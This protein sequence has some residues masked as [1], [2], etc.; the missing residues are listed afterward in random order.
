MLGF[1]MNCVDA[2]HKK[3]G[4][5]FDQPMP[6]DPLQ[7]LIE[8]AQAVIDISEDL[9]P[10]IK[11]DVRFLRAHL[12]FEEAGEMIKAM[13]EGDEVAALDGASDLQYVLS[14]TCVIFDWPADDAF[15]AVHKS[16]MSKTRKSD[17]PGRVRDKGDTFI[18]PN[19]EKVLEL[20]RMRPSKNRVLKDVEVP[21]LI[22]DQQGA[23]D[24]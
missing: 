9:E 16:N 2:F 24:E 7:E 19:I 21:N 17:D 15:A 11:E 14:G 18:P 20:H 8:A 5:D 10:R 22:A 4:I 13:A 6:K 12:I 1:I 3:M 23:K